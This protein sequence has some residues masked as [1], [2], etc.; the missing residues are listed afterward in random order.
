MSV[1]ALVDHVANSLS[2]PKKSVK[3]VIQATFEK[4][5]EEVITKDRLTITGFGA[6]KKVKRAARTGRNPRT[7]ESITIPPRLTVVF[8]PGE[9]L[10]RAVQS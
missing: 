9:H 2:I 8:T 4:M 7:G 5:T 1:E 10:K 6:F 3:Q